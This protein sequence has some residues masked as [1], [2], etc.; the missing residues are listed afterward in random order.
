[1]KSGVI[2]YFSGIG[3]LA[4]GKFCPLCYPVVG[5][6][7]S[8]IGVGLAVSAAVLQGLLIVFL[9]ITVFSFWSSAKIHNNKWPLLAA[10]LSVLLIYAGKYMETGVM[11]FYGGA[12]GLVVAAIVDIRLVIG[13]RPCPACRESVRA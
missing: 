5:S 11:V 2:N 9:V 13:R 8:Y 1:M 12:L 4:L 10:S 6:F 3:S 7:L